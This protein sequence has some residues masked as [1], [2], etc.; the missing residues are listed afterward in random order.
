MGVNFIQIL[1]K[2]NHNKKGAFFHLVNLYFNLVYIQGWL[3]TK[4]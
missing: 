2:V 3:L 4:S 1:F